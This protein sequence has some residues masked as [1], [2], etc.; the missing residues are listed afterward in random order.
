MNYLFFNKRVLIL[1]EIIN[2]KIISLEKLHNIT[3]INYKEIEFHINELIH[4]GLNIIKKINKNNKIFYYIKE[5]PETLNHYF[6][7]AILKKNQI[8]IKIMFFELIDSTNNLSKRLIDNKQINENFCLVISKK[9]IQGRG[10]KNNYWISNSN[11]NLYCS[12]ILKKTTDIKEINFYP[13][14][15]AS[16]ISSFITDEYHIP[17]YIK[18]PNDLMLNN[19]KIGGILIETKCYNKFLQYIICGI[20]I[21]IN[22]NNINL[23]TDIKEKS[24]SLY[25]YNNKKININIFLL[26]LLK[27][28][29]YFY[30]QFC[31]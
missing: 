20:G 5:Y 1:L 24:T 11:E 16:I 23:P 25:L 6:L 9:Q 30:K 19:K 26:K 18:N 31:S 13:I 2:I 14:Y 8:N 21:N 12:F 3:N 28:F 7:F 27:K 17:I 4:S 15:I 22:S 29:I 10:Q